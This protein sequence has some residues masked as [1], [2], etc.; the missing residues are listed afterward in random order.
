[1]KEATEKKVVEMS[2]PEKAPTM[3]AQI[4]GLQ[5]E[6]RVER[7][8]HTKLKQRVAE[9]EA[10][11]DRANEVAQLRDQ[12]EHLR[13]LIVHTVAVTSWKEVE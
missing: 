13:Q 9:T 8:L 3:K 7:M 5:R 6:L 11:P 12:V 1:M 10:Q 4:K 2:K